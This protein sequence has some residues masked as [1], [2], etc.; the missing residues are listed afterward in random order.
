MRAGLA[1]AARCSHGCSSAGHAQVRHREADQAR[2]SACAP[3]PVAPSSRISPPAPVAAPGKRR[4][5][6]RMVVRL[7]LHRGCASARVRAIDAVARREEAL[8]RRAPSIDRRVVGVRDEHAARAAPRACCWIIAN[9]DCGPAAAP[10]TIQLGV[11]DLVAAVLG[12]RLR[13]HHQLDVGRIAAELARS[14]STQVVDLVVG[15][16]EAERACS[17]RAASR[18]R[19]RRAATMPQRARRAGVRERRCAS[20]GSRDEH[21]LGHAIVRA[22]R[23]APRDVDR[24][25]DERPL[26]AALDARRPR[27]ARSCARCRSPSTTT[28]RSC[29]GAARSTKLHGLDGL[30]PAAG[31]RRLGRAVAQHLLELRGLVGRRA[32]ARR[33]RGAPSARR[34]TSTPG[35]DRARPSRAR[36]PAGPRSAPRGRE[37]IS[38]SRAPPA[39]PR[40]ARSARGVGHERPAGDQLVARDVAARRLDADLVGHHRRRAVAGPLRLVRRA[41]AA[42]TPCRGRAAPR[43]A[44]SAPRSRR[45]TSSATSPACGSRR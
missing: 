38:I 29:R 24:V 9:S 22:A 27:R 19:R 42:R 28:A 26:D 40:C 23:R 41:S 45:R 25:A 3:R 44:R 32:R 7:D 11:E 8:A 36:A 39:R 43:R 12:V 18:R 6:G 16:R 5:R 37:T 4:D 34:S 1:V 13:E 20:I 2:P 35:R 17:R 14:A 31:R 15:E 21:A 33:R 10:S 30:E